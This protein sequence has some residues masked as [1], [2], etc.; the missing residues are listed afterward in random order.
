MKKI[1]YSLSVIAAM[2]GGLTS[3]SKDFT[4]TEFHQS[5]VAGSITTVEQLDSFL[6][7]TFVKMRSTNYLG[8][9]YRAIGEVHTDEVFSNL[10]SGRNR[11]FATYTLLSTTPDVRNSWYSMYQVVGNANIVI[12]APDNL[13]LGGSAGSAANEQTK[14]LKGQA[15]ALRALALFDLLKLFGQEYSGGTLGVVLPTV[16]EPNAEMPRASVAETRRQ[17]ESDFNMALTLMGNS[18]NVGAKNYLNKNSVKALMSRYYLYKGDYATAASYAQE[19]IDS[20]AYSVIPAGDFVASFAKEN[21]PN[22]VFELTVGLNGS[23]GTTSYEY[24]MNENGYANME[25]L[26]S[27]KALYNTGDVRLD[28]FSG[29]FLNGKF[30]STKGT[31][32]IKVIRYEE[33]LLNAAEAYVMSG[34][35]ASALT[36]YNMV[37]QNR[38]LSAATSVSLSDIKDERIRE[39]IGEG[40]RYW[41]LL[42]WGDVIPFYD[43]TGT[44]DTSQDKNVGDHKLAFPIPLEETQRPGSLVRPNPGYDNSL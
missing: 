3:C 7:G 16:Y 36:Y 38:G 20:G 37:R 6:N 13:T 23:L 24:L 39:L 29:H 27:A 35:T 21:T 22:S 26:P 33:V 40:L 31:S 8:S 43:S 11:F 19:V 30:P 10:T 25:A 32:N 12:N 2:G 41:D 14:Y 17:I 34:N 44:R 18:G 42:R 5:E 15:Y 9:L 1:I 4:E 28:A